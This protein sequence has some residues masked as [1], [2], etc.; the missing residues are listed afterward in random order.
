MLC[1]FM[2]LESFLEYYFFW[3]VFLFLKCSFRSFVKLKL[4]NLE[5]KIQILYIYIE[6]VISGLDFLYIKKLVYVDVF[7][8]F[9]MVSKYFVVC[10]NFF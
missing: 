5:E 2:M 4:I 3:L 9:V 6:L 1:I 8:D 7:Q 10:I